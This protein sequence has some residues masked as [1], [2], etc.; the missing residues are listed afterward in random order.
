LSLYDNMKIIYINSSL[1]NEL[2]LNS[3]KLFND[4]FRMDI[5]GNLFLNKINGL[6]HG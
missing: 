3:I 2:S 6:L 4:K 1:R 5:I